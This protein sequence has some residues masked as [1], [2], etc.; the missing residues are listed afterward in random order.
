MAAQFDDGLLPHIGRY[1][2][3]KGDEGKRTLSAL[4]QPDEDAMGLGRAPVDDHYS[5]LPVLCQSLHDTT[6]GK[7]ADF[8][9]VR[10]EH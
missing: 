10:V 3:V 5:A 9:F 2:V 8:G 1:V 6:D 4:H 7:R